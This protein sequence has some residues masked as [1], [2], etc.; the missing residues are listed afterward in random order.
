MPE[1]VIDLII[2]GQDQFSPVVRKAAREVQ[3][4]AKEQQELLRG[5]TPL[6]PADS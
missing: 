4:L 5:M 3:N 1:D 2:K 6:A